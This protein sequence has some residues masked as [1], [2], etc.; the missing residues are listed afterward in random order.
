[1]MAHEWVRPDAMRRHYELFAQ[2][3]APHF[4]GSLDRLDGS[5]EFAV[6]RRAAR[7]GRMGTALEE[8]G[9][10]HAAEQAARHS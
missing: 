2:E 6:S 8:A 7:Y 10:R 1:M 4:Q 9:R 5:R 3:V